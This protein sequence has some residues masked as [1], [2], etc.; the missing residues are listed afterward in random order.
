MERMY[1][2]KIQASVESIFTMLAKRLDEEQMKMV[3][4]AYNFAAVAHKDQKRKTGEPYIIHPIAV[5]RIVAEEMG[6]GATATLLT[7][8]QRV[9]L[10]GKE[11]G[12]DFALH[13]ALGN[14]LL[15]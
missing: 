2:E 15:L 1:E 3:R 6:L 10:N 8:T 12:L 4:A 14:L 11:R 13:L 7:N 9:A 5:A